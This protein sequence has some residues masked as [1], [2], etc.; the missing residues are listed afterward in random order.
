MPVKI[1][2]ID[3]SMVAR[4]GLKN[5]LK[6]ELMDLKLT[7]AADGPEGLTRFA[8]VRPHLTFLDLTMPVTGGTGDLA[9]IM[10]GIMEADP[11][12]MV[13]ALTPDTQHKT[14]EWAVSLGA[15]MVLIKP[16]SQEDI[17][18]ALKELL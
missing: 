11:G 12:A 1:L 7:E 17:S 15:K 18:K 5:L 8:E 3:D 10:A 9:G 14:M 13:V 2:I 16:P 6:R 4:M